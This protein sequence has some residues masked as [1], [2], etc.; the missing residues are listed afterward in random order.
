MLVFHNELII[1]KYYIVL[2]KSS[3]KEGKTRAKS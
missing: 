3:M 2:A 1:Y